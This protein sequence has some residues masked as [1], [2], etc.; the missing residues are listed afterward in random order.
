[1]TTFL[2]LLI[3]AI[4]SSP[5][6]FC[7]FLCG[8]ALAYPETFLKLRKRLKRSRYFNYAKRY[9][10]QAANRDIKPDAWVLDPWEQHLLE[11]PPEPTPEQYLA[12][13]W[14]YHLKMAIG[15]TLCPLAGARNRWQLFRTAVVGFMLDYGIAKVKLTNCEPFQHSTAD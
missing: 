2:L 4:L 7:L 3:L 10:Y 8:L 11:K 14:L 12:Y 15:L 9:G 1:M 13:T 6:I 5:V